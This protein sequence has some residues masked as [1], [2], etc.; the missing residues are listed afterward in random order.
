MRRAI[1][2]P[3]NGSIPSTSRHAGDS[4][5]WSCE[6]NG[7]DR[8]TT[9]DCIYLLEG[10]NVCDLIQDKGKRDFLGRQG[11]EIGALSVNGCVHVSWNPR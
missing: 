6:K 4:I 11:N 1:L 10:L 9:H 5:V 2:T 8:D 7:H 3:P